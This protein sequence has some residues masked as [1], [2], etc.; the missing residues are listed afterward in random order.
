MIDLPDVTLVVPTTRAHDLARITINDIVGK[1]NFG[2]G[3]LIYTDDSE[4]LA[5]PCARY[6]K[7]AD[8]PNKNTASLFYYTEAA[9]K[10]T[11]SHALLMEWDAG[12]CNPEMWR[13]EFLEYDYIGAP[14]N[15]DM[16]RGWPGY[17]VG[18]GGFA[19][20]TKRLIDF[21]YDAKFKIYTDMHISRHHRKECEDRG[22]FKW[23]SDSIARDFAYEG[24][25]IHGPII[26]TSPPHSF[27]YHCVTNWPAILDRDDLIARAKILFASEHGRDKRGLLLRAAPWLRK[28]LDIPP[29]LEHSSAQ[30]QIN[31][32]RLMRQRSAIFANSLS[33]GLKA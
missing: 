3:V 6:I 2:G 26:P 15:A 21:C 17:T 13:D 9:R 24:W 22:G 16:G 5:V 7:V 10:I 31:H 18:N 14:W 20:V 32:Q 33:R 27:G 30:S 28:E 29:L 1:V 4:R 8:W 19:L 12:V 11:T 25:T 23:A